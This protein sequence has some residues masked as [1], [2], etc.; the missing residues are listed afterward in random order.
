MDTYLQ[1]EKIRFGD[2]IDWEFLV[3]PEARECQVLKFILQPLIENAV[4]HGFRSI[5]R[6]GFVRV[7]VELKEQNLEISVTDN[8]AGMEDEKYRAITEALARAA[9]DQTFTAR[10]G[11]MGIL[12][13]HRRLVNFYGPSFGLRYEQSEGGCGT[14][15]L[16][17]L[18]AV[19]VPAAPQR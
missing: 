3:P 16:L 10:D 17:L 11:F 6:K 9:G 19:F 13:V 1:V 4:V 15:A 5:T 2:K 8:G 14:R 18:P 7:A 12:N